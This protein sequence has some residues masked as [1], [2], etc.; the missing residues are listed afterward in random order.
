MQNR[1]Q[2][3]LEKKKTPFFI[4]INMLQLKIISRIR[5]ILRFKQ[6]KEVRL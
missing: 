4:I 3:K 2:K 6:N 1:V 5:N